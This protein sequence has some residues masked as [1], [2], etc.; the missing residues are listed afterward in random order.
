[1]EPKD[2]WE[3]EE[4]RQLSEDFRNYTTQGWQ[5]PLAMLGVDALFVTAVG[6]ILSK[7][8]PI[9]APMP[10]KLFVSGVI[11]LGAVILTILVKKHMRT[12][13][14]RTERT[15]EDLLAISSD[16]PNKDDKK[17]K[18]VRFKKREPNPPRTGYYLLYFMSGTAVVLLVASIVLFVLIVLPS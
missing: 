17:L 4:Y 1:M 3:I 10:A 2:E 6:T 12:W 9:P 14:T 7:D 11:L 13:Q 18:L 5:I 15:K 8:N 16:E